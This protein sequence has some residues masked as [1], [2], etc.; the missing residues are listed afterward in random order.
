MYPLYLLCI[1]CVCLSC[2]RYLG[3][4]CVSVC[5]DCCLPVLCAVLII[6]ECACTAFLLAAP[7]AERY[8]SNLPHGLDQIPTHTPPFLPPLVLFVSY[9]NSPWNAANSIERSDS[10]RCVR[11]RCCVGPCIL[12][13]DEQLQHLPPARAIT[14]AAV[15]MR[16]G[17]GVGSVL[18]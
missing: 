16:R 5:R 6:R 7:L 2:L 11:C 10:L 1:I 4:L 17:E 3:A 15:G 8:V 9:L 12:R 18:L 13:S 14:C